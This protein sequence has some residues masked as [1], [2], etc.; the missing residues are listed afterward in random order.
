VPRSA[1]YVALVASLVLVAL[2]AGCGSKSQP[3]RRG[4]V[5]AFKPPPNAKAGGTLTVVMASDVDHLDPGQ[6]YY[7][8]GYMLE[9]AV[10]RTL[11][12]FEPQDV[13][14]PHPDLA[15][16]AARVSADQKT[17]TIHIRRGV[18]YAPP[19]HQEVVADDIKYAIERGFSA[20]VANS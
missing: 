1:P 12:G 2:T 8:L 18:R 4:A 10:N 14:S 13:A 9:S 11:Y 3:A 6:T 15:T 5:G 7:S 19:L 17:I 20:H 16:G